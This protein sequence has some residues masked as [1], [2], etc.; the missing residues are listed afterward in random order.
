MHKILHNKNVVIENVSYDECISKYLTDNSFIYLDPPYRP[1]NKTSAFTSYTK[2]GFNDDNQK[3]LKICCDTIS[4]KNSYFMQSNSDPHNTDITDNF[5]D[6]LYTNYNI[7]RVYASRS[8]NSN[9]AKRGK[10]TELIIT[11]YVSKL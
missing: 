4:N 10:I 1:I 9:G 6:D 3:E 7:D 8:I 11:N 5:F 2:S